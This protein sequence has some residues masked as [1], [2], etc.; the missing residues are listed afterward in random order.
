LQRFANV[1]PKKVA[2]IPGLRCRD[3]AFEAQAN[4][5]HVDS[6]HD[7]NF[8]EREHVAGFSSN[9]K[10]GKSSD[11]RRPGQSVLNVVQD[12]TAPGWDSLGKWH[13]AAFR[14]RPAAKS[15]FV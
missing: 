11:L 12:G 14:N 2:S 3:A 6:C 4:A 10:H 8:A 9:A 5:F 13:V 15:R 1:C 7:E